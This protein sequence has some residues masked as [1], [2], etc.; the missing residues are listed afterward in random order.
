MTSTHHPIVWNHTPM[1]AIPTDQ[2]VR[3]H[4]T[5]WELHLLT[6][7]QPGQLCTAMV[8]S[9]QFFYVV[10]CYIAVPEEDIEL[11]GT[12]Q[13]PCLPVILPCLLKM[14]SHLL[15]TYLVTLYYTVAEDHAWVTCW[16][17][18]TSCHFQRAARDIIHYSQMHRYCI[19]NHVLGWNREDTQGTLC[20]AVCQR[21]ASCV[22]FDMWWCKHHSTM[23]FTRHAE[24]DGLKQGLIPWDKLHTWFVYN[25]NQ[26]LGS[27]WPY[28]ATVLYLLNSWWSITQRTAVV[29]GGKDLVS[30][31]HSRLLAS[32]IA[33]HIYFPGPEFAGNGEQLI[34]PHHPG[35]QRQQTQYMTDLLLQHWCR[36]ARGGWCS[37]TCGSCTPLANKCVD[38][39]PSGGASCAQRKLW[40]NCNQTWM[41]QGNYCKQTCGVW[42]ALNEMHVK[43]ACLVIDVDDSFEMQMWW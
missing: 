43:Y 22:M 11:H 34:K 32:S 10:W 41:V 14:K 13:L 26:T 38:I 20:D 12:L 35:Q 42:C 1:C 24:S 23:V 16:T 39:Q 37:A 21:S 28:V 9:P 17:T 3:R 29:Q 19:A 25:W 31:K 8:S 27:M 15:C 6:T 30:V 33:L 36:M 4:S 7:A 2:H 40:G 18:S 5:S